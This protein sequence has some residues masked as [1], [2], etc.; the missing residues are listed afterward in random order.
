MVE[1]EEVVC[2]V[3]GKEGNDIL[4]DFSCRAWEIN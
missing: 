3:M 2:E 4:E 1:V